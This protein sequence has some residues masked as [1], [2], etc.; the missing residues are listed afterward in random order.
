MDCSQVMKS[1]FFELLRELAKFCRDYQEG[2]ATL[3][4]EQRKE[5][6]ARKKQPKQVEKVGGAGENSNLISEKEKKWQ[7]SLGRRRIKAS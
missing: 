1:I 5:N 7:T 3:P 4:S 2:G 6:F